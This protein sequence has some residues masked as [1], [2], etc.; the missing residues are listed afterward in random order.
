VSEQLPPAVRARVVSI[1]ARTL[2]ELPDAEVPRALVRVR[3][4][5]PAKRV[6]LG[7][8]PLAAALESDATFRARVAADV[9]RDQPILVGALETADGPPPAAPPHDVAAVAYLLRLDGWEELVNAAA[10]DAEDAAGAAENATALREAR[11]ALE[12]ARRSARAERDA[13]RERLDAC[14]AEL[15]EVRRKLR[16]SADRSRRTELVVREAV[17]EAARAKAETEAVTREAEVESRRLRTR[18]QEL[19]AALGAARR[20]SRDARSMDTAQLR[21]LL[22]TL[23]ASA[24]G[25]R[26]A[27][28]LP[29]IGQRPG[30]LLGTSSVGVTSPF[31]GIN[32]RGLP[33][34]HPGIVDD[35]LAV[36]GLHLIVDGYNVTKRGYGTQ[37]LRSQRTRL[38]SAIATLATRMAGGEITVV[39]DAAD[40][41]ERPVGTNA[42]RNVRVV[43]SEPGELADQEIVKRVRA[44]PEGRPVV[45]VSSDREVADASAGA[46]AYPISSDALL[47][48]LS[49]T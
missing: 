32:R 9:R 24:N 47:A 19:E 46:G 30:D 34:D 3:Q 33:A 35:V 7:A 26:K 28:D 48:R 2:G 11:E 44:E 38:L 6:R 10:R 22:D 25:M 17:D 23:V 27:L 12:S 4:F 18:V 42:P 41:T 1:A 14:R 43:F 13:L 21:V 29:P 40:V 45:V 20:D 8:A 37:P 39:F 36:P 15:D 16:T 31:A 49:R 5:M